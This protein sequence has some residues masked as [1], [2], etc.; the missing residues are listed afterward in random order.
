MEGSTFRNTWVDL[1]NV[2]YHVE[3][4]IILIVWGRDLNSARIVV[5]QKYLV[6]AESRIAIK[7]VLGCENR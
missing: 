7:L 3:R 5:L 2:F 6:F 4:T 1:V